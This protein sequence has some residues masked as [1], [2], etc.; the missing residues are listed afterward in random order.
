MIMMI[1]NVWRQVS[2][3]VVMVGLSV[4]WTVDCGVFN[5]IKDAASASDPRCGEM[6]TGDFSHFSIKGQPVVEADVKAFMDASY[7]FNK[8]VVD[9]EASLIA[10]CASIGKDIGVDPVALDLKP[11]GGNSGA[12]VCGAVAAKVGDILKASPGTTLALNV[13]TPT[14]RLDIG[15]VTDCL[16]VPLDPAA[17]AL[18]CQGGDV[19]GQCDGDCQGTCSGAAG[20]GATQ[21]S[22]G[23]SAGGHCA[24]ACTGGCS[25]AYK[26]PTC[27]GDFKLPPGA[28]GEKKLIA[29]GLKGIAAT[30][31]DVPVDVTV[32]GSGSADV[33]KLVASLQANLPAI[34]AIQAGTAPKM[35]AAVAGVTKAGIDLKSTITQVGIHGGGCVAA[36]IA[37]VATAST[38]IKSN[39]D[40]SASVSVSLSGG[41]ALATASK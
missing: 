22:A 21:S 39:I 28:F 27:S 16:G 33:Q 7:T 19:G 41:G 14:C 34:A 40:A 20:A 13:G 32:N 37:K 9:T 30:K 3:P 4:P 6:E 29:C 18:S 35:V 24:G 36:G 2:W 10:S 23:G 5:G 25:V 11:D 17:L 12:K 38:A 8:I 1:W 31:C 26:A 15:A